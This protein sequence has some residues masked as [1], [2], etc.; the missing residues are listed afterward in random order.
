MVDVHKL[1]AEIARELGPEWSASPGH[2]NQPIDAYIRSRNDEGLHLI[3]GY[4]GRNKIT[5]SGERGPRQS[6]A[7]FWPRVDAYRREDP[8]INVSANKPAGQIAKDISRRLL[9]GYRAALAKAHESKAQDVRE[10]AEQDKIMAAVAQ[11]LSPLNGRRRKQTPDLVSFGS[12]GDGRPHGDV[13]IRQG[14]G[15]VLCEVRVPRSQIVKLARALA[16]L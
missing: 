7:D 13:T 14:C 2:Q 11:A 1:A 5:I 10:K 8:R 15:E 6:L 12:W 9:P 3:E 16:S 4:N